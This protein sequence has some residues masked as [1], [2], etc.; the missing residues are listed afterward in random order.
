MIGAVFIRRCMKILEHAG[1]ILEERFHL[2]E[3]LRDILEN[4]VLILEVPRYIRI[5]E[6]ILEHFT[7]Y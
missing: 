1:L 7:I 3:P 5:S 6:I 2:F 4:I